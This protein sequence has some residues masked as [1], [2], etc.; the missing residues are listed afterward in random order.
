MDTN[1]IQS[2]ASNINVAIGGVADVEQ[3]IA[4]TA[5]DLVTAQDLQVRAEIVRSEAQGQLDSAESVTLA[6]SQAEESQDAAD[7]AVTR[8][9]ADIDSA[10]SDLGQVT[11]PAAPVMTTLPDAL[12][13]PCY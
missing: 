9:R 5:D 3:I 7:M 10:R 12:A 13:L 6:L 4:D 8:T 2:L 11:P 1:Q